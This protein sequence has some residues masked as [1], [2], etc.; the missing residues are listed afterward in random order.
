MFGMGSKTIV[1]LDVSA[2]SSIKPWKLPGGPRTGSKV[3]HLGLERFAPDIAG[4]FDYRGLG[5][6]R[7]HRQT[8]RGTADQVESGGHGA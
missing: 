2:T 5:T 3:A 6:V 8:F 1:G 4:R 7:A